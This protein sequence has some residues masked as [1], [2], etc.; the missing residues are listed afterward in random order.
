MSKVFVAIDIGCLECTPE[1]AVLGIYPT[2]E[3]AEEICSVAAEEYEKDWHGQHDFKVFEA[4][5]TD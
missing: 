1:S 3:R 4:C 5:I 2:K